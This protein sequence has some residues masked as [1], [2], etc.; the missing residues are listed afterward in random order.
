MKPASL[1]W[2]GL[3]KPFRFQPSKSLV[4]GFSLFTIRRSFFSSKSPL[5]SSLN[6]IS[7]TL[8]HTASFSTSPN[9]SQPQHKHQGDSFGPRQ[10]KKM[11]P[12]DP[13]MSDSEIR[14]QILNA[15]LKRVPQDG[16]TV[17]AIDNG[18]LFLLF[19]PFS[20]ME[21]VL[22]CVAFVCSEHQR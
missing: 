4:H 22:S 12:F 10:E 20:L 19:R 18:S 5:S 13:S 17:Q 9:P 7:T 11:D 1:L 6:S 16:W 8:V 2:R 3:G 15:A 14:E 21:S